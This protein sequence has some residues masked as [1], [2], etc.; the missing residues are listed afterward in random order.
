MATIHYDK[1]DPNPKQM[2]I[3]VRKGEVGEYVIVPGDPFRCEIIAEHFE[4]ARLVAHNR[5]HKTYTGIYKGISVSVTSTG[6]GCPSAAIAAEELCKC[7]AKVLIRLGGCVPMKDDMKPG[8]IAISLASMKNEGTSRF[9]VPDGFP[10][11][12][13]LDLA[14][15]LIRSARR[16]LKGSGQNAHAGITSSN[17]AFYGETEEFTARMRSYGIMNMEMESSAIFTVCNRYNIRGGCIC[18]CGSNSSSP[19]ATAL[20]ELTTQRQIAITLEAIYEFDC[21][22]KQ[23]Q[24]LL[25]KE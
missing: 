17:D 10:A 8:D 19:E 6:M 11:L 1:N 14:S 2:H 23:G 7:G 25:N 5:E 18:A 22:K 4:N 12:A 9:F 13:D 16:E 15:C 21:L 20:R 3:E 24:L